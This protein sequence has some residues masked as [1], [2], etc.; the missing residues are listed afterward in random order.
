MDRA[1]T[2]LAE[3]T[4]GGNSDLQWILSEE[5]TRRQVHVH[6]DELDERLQGAAQAVLEL[7]GPAGRNA[8]LGGI[9]S[10]R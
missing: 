9:V 3:A 10:P 8:V 6:K 2:E 1:L 4:V 7:L 5:I